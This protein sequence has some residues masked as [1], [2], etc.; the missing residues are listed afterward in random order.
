[1]FSEVARGW[2]FAVTLGAMAQNLARLAL[3]S[4]AVSASFALAPAAFAAPGDPDPTFSGDGQLTF[5]PA[6]K[7]GSY[8]DVVVQPDGKLVLVGW[9][10]VNPGE[11][12]IAVTR[13][14]EDGSLDQS[15]GNA[16]TALVNA[17]DQIALGGTRSNDIA[18]AVALQ[19]D[20]KIVVA[21]AITHPSTTS[22]AVV[23][24]DQ[25]GVLDPSFNAAGA[26]GVP[27]GI[28]RTR[29]GFANDVAVDGNGK[30]IATGTWQRLNRPDT[31]G[32]IQRQNSNGTTDASLDP[33]GG[34]VFGST[35]NN[36]VSGLALQPGGGF[37]LAGWT[38]PAAAGDAGDAVITRL[39][40]SG[41]DTGFGSG[42]TRTLGFSPG[43]DDAATDVVVQPD[44]KIDIAGYG[45]ALND[46]TLTRLNADGTFDTS[47]NGGATVRADLGGT[48]SANALALLA[49]GK[50]VLGGYNGHDF[51]LARFQPGGTLDGTFGSGGKKTIAFAGTDAYAYG[52]AVQNDGKVVLVGRAGT[53]V[54]VARVLGDS[55]SE[56]GAGSGGGGG[57]GTSKAARC[58]GKR[59]TIVGTNKR[60][61][62]RGTKRADVI[63]GLGGNDTI[64]GLN[65]NDVVCGGSGNDKVS[66]GNGNDRISGGSG[67][68]SESGGAGKDKLSGDAGKDKLSGGSDKDKL[69]GGSG[70]DKLSGGPG[71][72]ALNGN[73]G[74]D[75]CAGSD[76]EKSC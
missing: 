48:D 46:F 49:N 21:G 69:S 58:A 27:P 15:F 7:S 59:A 64:S 24:L 17:I 57:G 75:R 28:T 51:A 44:Q 23:R 32:F 29:L 76:P 22:V 52:M 61:R 5:N 31:D 10:F 3:A 13:L 37:L 26:G 53:S 70:N 68:D 72:D 62:L 41:L 47:L 30:I 54:A 8:N 74:K 35:D 38:L 20:G 65:G 45:F 2:R 60:N 42:G 36:G 4:L 6:G 63:V 12:D 73:G 66:G 67:N 25:N 56:G 16:G 1:M 71:K 18:Y 19:G 39:T 33:M 50:L 43:S 11:T 14:N 34:G 40:D 55:A 9:A